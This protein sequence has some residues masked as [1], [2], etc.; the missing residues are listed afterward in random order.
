MK[1]NFCVIVAIVLLLIL[2]RHLYLYHT[3]DMKELMVWLKG[4]FGWKAALI[5]GVVYIFLLSIPFFPGVELAWLVIMIFGKEAVVMIFFFTICGLS[6]SFAIGRWFEKSW[7]TS[8]LDI[9]SLE[10]RFY[11]RIEKIKARI[12]KQLPEMF[13]SKTSRHLLPN[14]RY[15]ILAILI[16]LP[17]NTI[18]GGGGGIALL[19][20]MNRS[21]SWKGFIVT[22]ALAISPLPIL[23]FMGLIQIEAMMS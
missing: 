3:G 6:L 7:V 14:S 23:L 11:E 20:G 22:I 12:K 2:V 10:K 21:F 17:G 18:I 5:A 1:R 4:N 16:N 19:C 8:G 9:R 13:L 15:I